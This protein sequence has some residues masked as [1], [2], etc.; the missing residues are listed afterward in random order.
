MNTT[1]TN[2]LVLPTPCKERVV[3]LP[4]P[5]IVRQEEITRPVGYALPGY[6]AFSVTLEASGRTI[7]G[8]GEGSKELALQKATSEAM[9]RLALRLFCQN[10]GVSETSSGWAAHTVKNLAIR[11]SILELI[12]RDVALT[13]WENGGPFFLVPSTLWP[14]PIR[15]WR[16]ATRERAEY[17]DLKILLSKSGNGVC[18][19]ALLFNGRGNFVA[20]HASAFQIEDAIISAANECMR[21]AHLAIR[22]EYLSDVL[23]LHADTD[24][25]KP[26]EPG[27]HS[28]AYA[29]RETMPK[30]ILFKEASDG[31]IL[32]WWSAHQADLND[33]DLREMDISLFEIGDRFV[34]RVKSARYRE[35]YWGKNQDL[36][37]RKLS[38]HFVG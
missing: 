8:F 28:L 19:S 13:T 23:A 12:E 31:E 20:G 15:A 26:I 17:F 7:T 3:F 36:S 33:L 6:Q 14:A 38:P 16:E 29:Y 11:S 35:I 18:I 32:S 24:P 37:K 10:A 5:M 2:S 25:A 1:A 27:A 4:A 9:E 22:F 21:A 30:E 34:A